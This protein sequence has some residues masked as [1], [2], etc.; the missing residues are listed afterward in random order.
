M[1]KRR[2]AVG[3]AGKREFSRSKRASTRIHFCE[4]EVWNLKQ[5]DA[6]RKDANKVGDSRKTWRRF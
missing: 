3:E 2:F 6:G 4:M 5:G 1:S